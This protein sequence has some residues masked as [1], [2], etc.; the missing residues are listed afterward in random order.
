MKI[1]VA[2]ASG[3]LGRPLI[4]RLHEAGHDVWGLASRRASLDAITAPGAHAINGNAM[5]Y[6]GIFTILEQLR[7]DVVIDQ[8]TSL[9]A[10]PFD[11]ANRLAADRHLRLEGGGNLFAAA[12]DCQGTRYIQQSWG[13]YLDT[14][15]PLATE[16][17]P[18][19]THAPGDIGES[20]RM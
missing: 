18:L 1:L 13:F 19:R 6:S 4:T 2:G 16:E 11:L 17:S 9:P 3:A 15:G 7:P 14:N 10:S 8:L 5:D 20:A 12:Q